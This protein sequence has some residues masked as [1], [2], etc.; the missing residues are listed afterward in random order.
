MRSNCRPQSELRNIL[1]GLA[2]PYG[3]ATLCMLHC[4]ACVALGVKDHADLTSSPPSSP[5]SGAVSDEKYNIQQG[6]RSFPD[7]TE[8]FTAR[9]DDNHAVPVTRFPKALSLFSKIP[10]ISSP[11]KV[12]RLPSN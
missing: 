4:S 2:P 12:T 6:L 10:R 11:G 1:K 7:L 5:L 8:H 9:A 3:L